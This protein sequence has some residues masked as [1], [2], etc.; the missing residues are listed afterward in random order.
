LLALLVSPSPNLQILTQ[1]ALATSVGSLEDAIQRK[2]RICSERTNLDSVRA[3]YPSLTDS[4]FVVDPPELGGDGRPGFSCPNCQAR[5][6][7]FDFL[8]AKRAGSDD[9]YCHASIAPAE[10]LEVRLGSGYHCNK[11]MIGTKLSTVQMG[12]PINE[13]KSAELIAFFHSLKNKGVFDRQIL[14]NRPQ[15]MCSNSPNEPVAEGEA[16]NIQQLSCI[17]IVSGF[18]GLLGILVS[19]SRPKIEVR[20]RKSVHP[21]NHYDQM[22]NRINVLEQ[23]NQLVDE[24]T[25]ERDGRRLL[26]GETFDT[27]SERVYRKSNDS[28]SK[29]LSR[30][31]S[32]IDAARFISRGNLS[33]DRTIPDGGSGPEALLQE[34]GSCASSKSIG[35]ETY[36]DNTILAIDA[37]LG[38]TDE[39]ES[40]EQPRVDQE[41]GSHTSPAEELVGRLAGIF[42]AKVPSP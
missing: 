36:A 21:V 31:R 14:L 19:W 15:P 8:D 16:L 38:N 35:I 12:I 7:V 37:N 2:Y 40:S 34:R 11:T 32:R 33:V 9:R 3:L 24:S 6:R 5:S 4:N 22:G 29:V 18:F 10:D 17:W 26:R 13:A 30:V 23:D 41:R 25:F 20:R 1:N 42:S 28:T 39:E 27:V